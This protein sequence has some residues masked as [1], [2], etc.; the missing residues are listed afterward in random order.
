MKIYVLETKT[1]FADKD[2]SAIL[3]TVGDLL[4][5]KDSKRADNLVKR[6]LV[7]VLGVLDTSSAAKTND[8]VNKSAD[9]QDDK[10]EQTPEEGVPA[11][12]QDDK[13]EQTPEEPKDSS[14]NKNKSKN[15]NSKK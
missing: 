9:N 7:E 1:V 14:A 8:S 4:A 12:N 10:G 13:G 2:N 5:I 15:S 6:G 11:D 3:Y